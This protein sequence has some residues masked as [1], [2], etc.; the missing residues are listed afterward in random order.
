MDASRLADVV[1]LN[2]E[3]T[4]FFFFD[5]LWLLYYSRNAKVLGLFSFY[6]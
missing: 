4:C 2:F 3:A 1:S 5:P 6:F